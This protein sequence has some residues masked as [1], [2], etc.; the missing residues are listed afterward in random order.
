MKSLGDSKKL[1]NSVQENRKILLHRLQKNL[2]RSKQ[3]QVNHAKEVE[4]A[5]LQKNRQRSERN[6]VNHAEEVEVAKGDY[7]EESN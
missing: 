3:N 6:P 1:P 5:K 4:V 2:Q 7:S